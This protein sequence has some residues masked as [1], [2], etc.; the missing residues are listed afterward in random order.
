[1]ALSAGPK[2][3]ASS[4]LDVVT[5]GYTAIPSADMHQ[6]INAIGLVLAALPMSYWS[7]L[8]DRLLETLNEL[9]QWPF[10]C[11]P[12]RLFNFEETH[13]GL[14]HNRFSYMLALAHSVWHH[15]G[16]GQMASVP[17]WVRERLPA[18]V[19]SEPQ[20]LFV[21][22]LVGPF[23]QRFNVAIVEL[24]GALYELLA[25]VDHNQ[26]QLEYMD[27]ICDLLYHIKYM[28]VG[29]S[30][31]KELEGVVRRLRPAL[32][33]RLRFIAHLAV[34]EVNAC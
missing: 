12:F 16:P 2:V 10:D 6:W 24:T 32:Q 19:R 29:D 34:E 5:R 4:L 22:H 13:N 7:V 27:P 33:L 26:A 15:A 25:Q 1:M 8:L 17:R 23:L 14:L 11:S 3:V 20:F 31:K 9:E 18:I 21:C 30:M 28:F